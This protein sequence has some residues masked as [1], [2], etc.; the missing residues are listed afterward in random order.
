MPPSEKKL[1]L[2]T[3]TSLV[4]GNMI[5]AGVFLMPAAMASFGSIGLLGWVFSA[6]G[7]FFLAKVFSNL[8]KL[9]PHA[10]GGPYAFTHTGFGDFAGFLVAWGYFIAT[11]CANAAITISLVSALSTFFPVLATNPVAAISTGLCAIWFITYINTLGVVTSGK[12]QLTTTI[13]KVLPLLLIA[14][15]G[16]FFIQAKNFIPF[17]SSGK[18]TFDAITATAAMTMFSFIGIECA[19]VPAGSVENPGKTIPRATI[20]GLLIATLIYILGSVSVMGV[21][22]ASVLQHSVTPYA[23]AAVI[24][25]GSNARYWVSA[26]VAI[27]AF[28][29]LNG[30]TLMQGQ[31]PF[32]IAK[33]K[34]FPA[35]FSK[36]NKKGVPYVGILLNSVLVSLFMSMNYTKGLVEQFRFLLL[37]SLLSMLIPYLLSAAAYLVIKAAKKQTT[38]WPGA[39]ALAVLAFSYALWN[40]A[41]TGKD[42]VYY[43]FLLLMASVP[44]YVWVAYKKA[45]E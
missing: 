25:Y 39:V 32:A 8:S 3:S 11:S 4:V 13:L 36:Q 28:G 6:I 24:I 17:N 41:G 38:G 10:T 12:L 22:P 21:I 1:G 23:D 43:G 26:G 33:D 35:I 45:G 14:I 18:T 34:L 42:A 44:F 37:L 29:A 27:A 2:W 9:L 30:W 40:I 7:S 19:T 31:M 16:L 15:G 5:G 20:L